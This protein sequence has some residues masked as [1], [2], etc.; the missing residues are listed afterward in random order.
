MGEQCTSCAKAIATQ[1]WPASIEKGGAGGLP[2]PCPHPALFDELGAPTPLPPARNSVI[3]NEVSSPPT[4]PPSQLAPRAALISLNRRSAGIGSKPRH[5]SGPGA[6]LVGRSG[7]EA[8]KRAKLPVVLAGGGVGG[9]DAADHCPHQALT[10]EIA[11]ELTMRRVR[12]PGRAASR[13][14]QREETEIGLA[15]LAPAEAQRA[16][17]W[18]ARVPAQSRRSDAA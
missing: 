13:P 4:L 1:K 16:K 12:S 15:F 14:C 6:P 3:F 17:G 2:F 10:A 5:L 8:V 11:H 18:T 7:L 9:G